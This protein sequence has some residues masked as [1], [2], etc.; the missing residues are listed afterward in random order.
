MILAA[1]AAS[2]S[3]SSKLPYQWVAV[4]DNGSLYTSTSST[5]SSWTSRTSSFSSTAIRDVATDTFSYVAVGDSGKLATSPDGIT[6]TQQTSGFG[7]TGITS[8]AY[9]NGYWVAVGNSGKMSYSTNGTTWTSN[10]GLGLSIVNT[11]SAVE[12]GNG[13]WAIIRDNGAVYTN[14]TPVGTWTARTSTLAAGGQT[15]RAIWY[16]PDQSIW[17]AGSDSGTTGALASSTDAATWTARTSAIDMASSRTMFVSNT[18]T[19][20]CRVQ[21]RTTA[22]GDVQNSTNGT[23]WTNQIPA[24][25]TIQMYTSAVDDAGL[26]AIAG[27]VVE[28]STD[29]SSWTDR[30]AIVAGPN[31]YGLCHSAGKPAIR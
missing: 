31:C 12:W 24:N 7:T 25:T 8:V 29:G 27:A 22:L 19:I 9:G 15:N 4:M 10:D 21:T 30:G 20:A 26:M 16:W 2:A 17:V 3:G 23:T 6:W 5:A 1:K 11:L 28:T 14:T 18:S 13:T